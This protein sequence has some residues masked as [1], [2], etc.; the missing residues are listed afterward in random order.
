MDV[1]ITS[2]FSPGIRRQV[3]GHRVI[4]HDTNYNYRQ[5]GGE[6]V[7]CEIPTG[8]IKYGAHRFTPGI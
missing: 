1:S 8:S 5:E 7:K 2:V 4:Y 3:V 6:I